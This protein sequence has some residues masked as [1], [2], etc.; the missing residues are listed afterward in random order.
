V[1][2]MIETPSEYLTGDA[3]LKSTT[4]T[5]WTST[6]DLSFKGERREVEIHLS[7]DEARLLALRLT[8]LA[9]AADPIRVG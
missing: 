6:V 2:Y 9:D 5:D 7:P 8:R 1:H 4:D 3:E